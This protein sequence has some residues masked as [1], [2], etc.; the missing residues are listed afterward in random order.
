MMRLPVFGGELYTTMQERAHISHD[1][2]VWT[3]ASL[4]EVAGVSIGTIAEECKALRLAFLTCYEDVERACV[5]A[6]V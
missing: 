4:L 1:V 5:C 2:A 6:C 3:I